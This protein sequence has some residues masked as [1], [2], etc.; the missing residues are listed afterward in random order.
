MNTNRLKKKFGYSAIH[1][2]IYRHKPKKE[3]CEICNKKKDVY[4]ILVIKKYD[5]NL[6]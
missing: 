1:K 2:W 4:G 6:N 5:N 3:I